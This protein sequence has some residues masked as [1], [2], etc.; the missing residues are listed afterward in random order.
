M[1]DNARHVLVL[2]HLAKRTIA[3]KIITYSHFLFWLG[4]MEWLKITLRILIFSSP[5]SIK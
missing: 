2:L 3:A 5:M 4:I 1:M